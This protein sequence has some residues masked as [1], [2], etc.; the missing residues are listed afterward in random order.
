MCGILG[1]VATTAV[2]QLL[3]DG[4][5]VLQHRGQDAAGIVTAE[6]DAFHMHKGPGLVRDVFRTRNMRALPGQMGIAH[7]RYPTAGSAFDAALS[8]PF[9]V[10]SPFGIVLGHNGNLTNTEQ[11]KEEMYRLDLRHINTTSDSEV[12]LNTLAHELQ[13][14]AKGCHL[15]LDTIFSAVAAVHR[16]CRGAYAVVAMIAGHGML[17]FRDPFGIRPLV[18]GINETTAGPE[19]LFASESVALDTLGFRVLRDV[20]PGE[21]IFIDLEHRLHQRQC[22][23]RAVLSP[24]IFEFVYL[25]RPDSVIDGVSVYEAR[26]RM[27]EHLADKLVRYIPVEEIDVVIP[28]PD[29][30]RPSA[31]QL[32]ERIAVPYREGF[33]K[34]RYIGRTFIMP[35]QATRKR[36]VRQKLNTVAQE[37]RGKRVLLVDDSIVRGTTSREI[38]EMARAAGALKVYFASAS[39][40]VRYPNVYGIDMPTR[41]ELIATGRSAEDIAREIGAD[42]LVYQDL[43][44]LRASISELRPDLHCFDTSCFDGSYVTGDVDEDY[45]AALEL[46]R[47]GRHGLSRESRWAS[48]QLQLNLLTAK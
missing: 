27:G 15:N 45:L 29:S 21:A 11:L 9:Y 28:I 37:F 3:Y 41:A 6:S 25:A 10:N 14:S 26:L 8:Q 38:V 7:C 2:N 46:A 36:S 30:S 16:R 42:A 22:A 1:V 13:S 48:K 19:Y 24:C 44:E 4:L 23:S 17:A 35:G 47:D 34:N 5:M 12:L 20:A 31:M 18:F 33:V 39:P 32:A 40:P 43:D